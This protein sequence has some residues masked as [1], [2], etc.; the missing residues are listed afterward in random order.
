M[1]PFSIN[2]PNSVL[3]GVEG[4]ELTMVLFPSGSEHYRRYALKWCPLKKLG[5]AMEQFLADKQHTAT[6]AMVIARSSV[7]P[8]A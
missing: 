8:L 1:L 7:R 6:E 3:L 5:I 4:M 2:G